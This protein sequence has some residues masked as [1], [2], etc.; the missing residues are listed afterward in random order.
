MSKHGLLSALDMVGRVITVG[1]AVEH[2]KTD[3]D[4][5][6]YALLLSIT[7]VCPEVWIAELDFR[8]FMDHNRPLMQPNHYDKDGNPTLTALDANTWKGINTWF[9]PTPGQTW[10]QRLLPG[11]R[12][13]G[14][15]GG[16]QIDGKGRRFLSIF[17]NTEAHAQW[18]RCS[19]DDLRDVHRRLNG[20]LNTMPR[21]AAA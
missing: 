9:L 12:W 16:F 4:E 20:G 17:A 7:E 14:A 13:R 19:E 10:Q 3:F 5:G 6:M 2:D 21:H 8:P 18:T 1:P 11:P 15:V